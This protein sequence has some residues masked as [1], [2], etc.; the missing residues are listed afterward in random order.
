MKRNKNLS[1]PYVA[2]DYEETWF[3]AREGYA[4]MFTPA[5][6][7]SSAIV[8]QFP[9]KFAGMPEMPETGMGGMSDSASLNWLI[10]TAPL[11]ILAG[12]YAVRRK[13]SAE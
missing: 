1:L 7:F 10:W 8:T 6:L 3:S 9:D 4:H 13:V 5:K 2:G 12:A 11:F